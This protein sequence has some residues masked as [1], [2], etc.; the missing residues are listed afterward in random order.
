MNDITTRT[1][2]DLIMRVF[3]E[4]ALAD[5]VIGYIFRDVAKLDLESH[6][7]IIG[8]FWESLLFGTRAY[9]KHGRNPMMVHKSLHLKERLRAEHF[10]RWLKIFE[11][12]VDEE[13]AG[14]MADLIKLRANSIAMQFQRFLNSEDD[15]TVKISKNPVEVSSHQ[16]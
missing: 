7:P 14:E 15:I 4:R 11:S 10:E 5:E 1:D 8:D 6:L 9:Q 16:L 2:I 13:F 3:Y 12:S